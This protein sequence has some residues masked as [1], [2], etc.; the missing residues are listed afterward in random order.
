MYRLITLL[1][2]ALI[3]FVIWV[4]YQANTGGHSVFFDIVRTTRDGD[5]IGHFFLY[6]LLVLG[7]N[8]ALRFKMLGGPPYGIYWGTLAVSAFVV[9]EELS[10]SFFPGRTVDIKDLYADGAGILSFT[11]ITALIHMSL[12]FLS[13]RQLR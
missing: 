7:C 3:G 12:Y 5:K 6:G 8:C 2:F 9:L 4:N 10:Q 13:Q 11:V 1:N